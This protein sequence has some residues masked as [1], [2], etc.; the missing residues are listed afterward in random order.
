M[1]SEFGLGTDLLIYFDG[2]ILEVQDT[3]MG[4]R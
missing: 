4:T 3:S 2:I 1:L